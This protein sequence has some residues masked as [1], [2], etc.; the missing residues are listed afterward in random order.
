M[1]KRQIQPAC[2]LLLFDGVEVVADQ[3]VHLEHVDLVLF[4]HSLHHVV[5]KN[6]ALVIRV[7]EIVGLDMLPQLLD[8]LRAGKL[9]GVA[10]ILPVSSSGQTWIHFVAVPT[11]DGTAH[12]PCHPKL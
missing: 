12:L 4:E 9:Y 7:L 11:D 10:D 6:L 2:L 1:V 5:A 8:D 3:L